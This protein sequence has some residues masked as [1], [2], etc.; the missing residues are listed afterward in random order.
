MNSSPPMNP[1]VVKLVAA[2]GAAVVVLTVTVL[3]VGLTLIASLGGALGGGCGGDGGPGGGARQVGPRVWS[4]EQMTNAQTIV[5]LAVERRLP[6]RAAV[7]AV[8]TAIVESGLQN[9]RY[10]LDDSLGLFQQRPSMSWGSADQVLNPAYAAG[11]FYDRLLAV[12]GWVTL[13][14]GQAAE[15][16]QASGYPGRYGPQEPAAAALVEQFWQGPDNPVPDPAA[17]VSDAQGGQAQLA[18]LA[19][20]LCPDQGAGGLPPGGPA[21]VDPGRLP[22]GFRLPTDPQQRA[23]VSYA[24]AQLGKPYVWG[25]KGP[26]A[27][28]CSGLMTA[29]WAAAGVPIPAGTVNQKFVGTPASFARLSPGD[30]VFI[31]GSLGSPTNPRHVGMY[32]GN[33]IIV[34]AYDSSSGVILQPVSKWADQVVAVRHIAGPVG[35]T[36]GTASTVAQGAPA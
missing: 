19:T 6:K 36:P 16:V 25:A 8:S 20:T 32:A 28:D 18:S 29:A 15:T 31:P 35:E 11:T 26:G 30:L 10:G 7:I 13:S 4:A 21:L 24:L 5:G 14:P 3:V 9:V 17:L 27:F 2:I 23:A 33:G 12:P 34:N 22:A 1:S